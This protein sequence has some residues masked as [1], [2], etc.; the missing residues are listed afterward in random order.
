MSTLHLLWI[1]FLPKNFALT[2]SYYTTF[3][4]PVKQKK[5]ET[6]SVLRKKTMREHDGI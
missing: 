2:F 1:T 5:T 3:T 4:S 6:S